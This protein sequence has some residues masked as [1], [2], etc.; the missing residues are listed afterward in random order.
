MNAWSRLFPSVPAWLAIFGLGF[1]IVRFL[2][3]RTG[4]LPPRSWPVF[5]AW[6]LRPWTAWAFFNLFYRWHWAAGFNNRRTFPFY[7]NPWMPEETWGEALRRIAHAPGLPWGLAA[8]VLLLALLLLLA[9]FLRRNPARPGPALAALVLLAAGLHLSLAGLPNGS[10]GDPDRRGTLVSGW[11]HIH[12]T[13]LH[14]MPLVQSSGD[15]YRRF[16][17]IQPRLRQTIHGLSHP[18]AASLSL[19]WLGHLCGAKGQEID[20]PETRLRY[21]VG[22]TVFGALN[23]LVLFGLGRAMFDARVGFLAATL[24]ATAPAVAAYATFAQDSVYAVFFNLA[25]WLGWQT[26]TAARRAA[27][28]AVLLGLDFFALT[29][30]SYSWCLATTIFALFALAAGRRQRWHVQDWFV[31]LIL[32]LAVMTGLTSALLAWFRLDYWTM[33]R[34]ASLYVNQWYPFT[35]PY[36]WLMALAGGQLDL[37]LLLGSVTCAAF[38]VSLAALRRP[39]F[40]APRGT[41]LAIV[42]GV[43]ALPLLFG[44]NC[45]KMET[46]RCWIWVASLPLAFAARRLLDMPGR[47]F[48]LGAP[49]VSAAT[50]AGLRLF[51]DFST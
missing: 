50:Y 18:P 41:Y 32:P 51:L 47:L 45:L 1:E 48:V 49:A 8:A 30:L 43:F 35:G 37:W 22:L 29:Q 31:R 19:Y 46:A 38:L 26:A 21:A 14:A 9:W 15:Y 17:E 25:L 42:L 7:A 13:M 2:A 34:Q 28:W 3:A 11:D 23:A 27:V 4:R 20:R 44:P 10:R 12:S 40:A 36:Q 6:A 16:L 5:L 24:W 33:Y 39:D